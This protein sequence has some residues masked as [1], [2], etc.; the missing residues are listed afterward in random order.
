MHGD[1]FCKVGYLTSLYFYLSVSI[2]SPISSL[3]QKAD[4]PNY[5]HTL[6][7]LSDITTFFG[8]DRLANFKVILRCRINLF[9]VCWMLELGIGGA[10]A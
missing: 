8:I 4:L 7:D 2:F 6:Q 10:S 9:P 1:L 5:E 3:L